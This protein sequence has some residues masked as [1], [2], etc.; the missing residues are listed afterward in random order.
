MA[1]FFGIETS[2]EDRERIRQDIVRKWET[3]GFLDEIEDQTRTNIATLYESQAA[4]LLNEETE[5]VNHVDWPSFPVVRRVYSHL[6][7]LDNVQPIEWKE[8]DFKPHNKIKKHR[9]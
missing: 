8:L 9:L 7:G 1:D 4:T 6:L 5:V 3:L 2:D